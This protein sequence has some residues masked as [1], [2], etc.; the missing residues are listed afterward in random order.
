VAQ[1]S[2]GSSRRRAASGATL[3]DVAQLVGVS[4]RTVSRVVNGEGGCTPE[5]RDRILAAIDEVGYRPNLM[6]R[7]LIRRR[8]DT[9]GLIAA[10]MLDPFF[11]EFAEGVQRAADELRRTM[12]LAS[13]E[14]SA[15]RQ[16]RALASLRGHGVDGVIVFPTLGSEADLATAAADGLPI[17]TV[18]TRVD[19][20]GIAIV[21]ADI[22]GGAV[23][24]VEHLVERGR[25][26]VALVIDGHARSASAPSRRETGY[27][28]VLERHGG[29]DESLIV[30]TANSLNGGRTAGRRLLEM[31]E[32][33]DAVFVYND[34]MAIGVMQQLLAAGV[35][36][37][38]DVAV[39]GFDDIMMCE[40]VTP[41]LSSVRIDRDLL[42][43][44]AVDQLQALLDD[45]DRVVP[46]AH[47][48]VELVV[49]QSS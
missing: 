49:R 7:G 38:D 15:E 31:T 44:T 24:A 37:P 9:I 47:L 41:A 33:P 26:R 34:I 29:V 48:A 20:P 12:F 16:R 42:G 43:R 18:N 23:A 32:R 17:V 19:A 39:V 14:S 21:T 30:E 10:E 2:A 28:S 13:S 11:P 22:S 25:R 46:P 35:R 1:R 40:A 5:T 4:A 45:P 27:R 6:A 8:S 36:I 3:T